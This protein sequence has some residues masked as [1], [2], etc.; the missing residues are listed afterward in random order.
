MLGEKEA[1]SFLKK[2]N[3]SIIQAWENYKV[4]V[5]HSKNSQLDGVFEQMFKAWMLSNKKAISLLEKTPKKARKSKKTT[6]TKETKTKKTIPK[7]RKK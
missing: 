2:N 7:T 4:Q 6:K 1:L 3:K 5:G